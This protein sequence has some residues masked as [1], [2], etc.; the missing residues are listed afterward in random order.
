MV[1]NSLSKVTRQDT[2]GVRGIL[3]VGDLAVDNYAAGGDVGRI[4]TGNGTTN[5][6]LAFRDEIDTSNGTAM[7]SGTS[8][9]VSALTA[10]TAGEIVY[11][12][13][14]GAHVYYNHIDNLWKYLRDDSVLQKYGHGTG[15][16]GVWVESWE[17]DSTIFDNW[18]SDDWGTLNNGSSTGKWN[19][20]KNSTGSSNTGPSSA[21]EGTWY[22]YS[23]M[24]SNGHNTQFKLNTTN[25]SKLTNLKF[26]YHMYGSSC[27]WLKVVTITGGVETERW[28]IGGNQGNSWK[29][30]DLDL[31]DSDAEEISIRFEGSTGWAADL[32]LDKIEITST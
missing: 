6:A 18:T 1:P 22:V 14:I 17:D 24:S 5:R 29:V 21:Y 4:W 10:L 2:D 31:S 19:R 11:V 26:R 25:F 9:E 27:G 12:T 16:S 23:E 30:I 28:S 8:S 7:R 20:H 32:A 13:D 15:P 3:S